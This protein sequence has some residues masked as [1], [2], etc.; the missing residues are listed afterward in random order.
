LGKLGY[1]QHWWQS[2]ALAE[3]GLDNANMKDMHGRRWIWWHTGRFQ[4]QWAAAGLQLILC[5]WRFRQHQLRP[6][7]H[8]W[9][10]C[11]QRI[12]GG[13]DSPW[14]HPKPGI[15]RCASGVSRPQL[16]VLGRVW[17]GT[18]WSVHVP[19]P[20]R[21][22]RHPWKSLHLLEGQCLRRF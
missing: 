21:N 5:R 1:R 11:N 13:N 12:D 17:S 19:D 8:S 9:G 20:L 2:G 3:L 18:R 15:G 7:K 16:N 6:L 14:H 22:E 4:C 10:N